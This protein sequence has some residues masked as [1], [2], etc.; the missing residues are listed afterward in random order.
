MLK[1]KIIATG[2]QN[3]YLIDNGETI[4]Q[5]DMG[6]PVKKLT[7]NPDFVIYSHEHSD[8]FCNEKTYRKKFNVVDFRHKNECKRLDSYYIHSTPLRHGKEWSNGFVI[9]DMK[10][11][12]IYI[13]A[14]DFSEYRELADIALTYSKAYQEPITHIL[15]ELHHTQSIV[16]TMPEQVIWASRRHCSD[17]LFLDF[18]SN[19]PKSDLKAVIATHTNNQLFDFFKLKTDYPVVF[20]KNGKEFMCK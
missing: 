19:F 17:E 15:C 16:D 5:I 3:A 4:L 13:F 12:Q 9:R 2:N 14:I 18:I 6:V 20:A 8:H 10:L 1:I 11:N 7:D